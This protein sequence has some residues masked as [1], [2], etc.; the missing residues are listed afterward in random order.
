M[1]IALVAVAAALLVGFS[2][3]VNAADATGEPVVVTIKDHAFVP[4]EIRV[5]ANTETTLVVKNE[6]ATAEEFDSHDL[7][8]EKVIAAGREGTIKLRPLKPGTYK[9]VGEFHESTAKGVIIAE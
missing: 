1:R 6:D 3:I 8:I 5:K 2:P 7:K 9:F 4:S